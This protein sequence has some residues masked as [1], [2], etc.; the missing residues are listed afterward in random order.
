MPVRLSEID[1][2]NRGAHYHLNAGDNCLYLY[3]Y[4]SG[5]G[6]SFSTTNQLITNLK[7]K[8]TVSQA[9]LRYKAGAILECAAAFGEALN[10]KW[11]DIATIVPVPCSK[12]VGHPD[13]DRRMER[14][15]GLIRK[16]ADVRNLVVQ[17]EST[18]AAH[19]AEPGQ[20]ITVDQLLALYEIDE[21]LTAPAPRSIGI[22]DDVLT[23][24][25][26][27]RAMSTVL[28]QRFPGVPIVGLFVA[29]RVFP[30]AA[31]DFEGV[32]LEDLL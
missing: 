18:V 25:T 27:F 23:A 17:R 16:G 32:N 8:P 31:L 2:S 15:A 9:Q 10:P 19:E 24:G 1:D 12:A 21:S 26:H 22:L 5:Q 20:R 3:E 13:Y 4:T 30:P 29:R 14:M 6:Y 11:L 28:S 7:K